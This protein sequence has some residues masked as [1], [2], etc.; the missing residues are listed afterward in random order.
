M[1]IKPF[2]KGERVAAATITRRHGKHAIRALMAEGFIDSAES[3]RS[4]YR[5]K[6]AKQAFTVVKVFP[7]DVSACI[8]EHF[9]VPVI[10]ALDDAFSEIESLKEELQEWY[11]NL[12]ESFQNGDKGDA[13]QSAISELEGVDDFRSGYKDA[14]IERLFKTMPGIVV[15]PSS[16]PSRSDRCCSAANAFQAVKKAIDNN[17]VLADKPDDEKTLESFS[18]YL[19]DT[20][21][22]LQSV[23]FPGMY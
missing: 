13:L 3:S 7:T 10:R 5:K 12:P 23:D 22:T 16:G 1:T 11:D 15:W 6:G 4:M 2:K 20:V 18:S 17:I 14:E 19:D 9:R 8:T 21:Q